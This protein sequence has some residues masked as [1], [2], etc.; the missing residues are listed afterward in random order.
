MEQASGGTFIGA[1][2]KQAIHEKQAPIFV[3][4]A[5]PKTE[6]QWGDEQTIYHVRFNADASGDMYL[7]A[8]THTLHRE[9]LA[10]S[11]KMLTAAQPGDA[12]GPFY[13]HKFQTSS[14]NEAW[15]LKTEP[16]TTPI[17]QS[18]PPPRAA[19]AT[20]V[21]SDDDLPF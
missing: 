20:P 9:R 17:A 7:L 3:Y 13:L 19:T 10:A 15:S 5:E 12:V 21:V 8:F 1:D 11:C 4:D 16:Q 6:S 18:T 2:K 14:G